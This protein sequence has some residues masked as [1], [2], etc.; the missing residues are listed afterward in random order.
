MC[1]TFG[2]NVRH[3]FHNFVRKTATCDTERLALLGAALVLPFVIVGSLYATAVPSRVLSMLFLNSAQHQVDTALASEARDLETH[4]R[5][6]STL[7]TVRHHLAENDTEGLTWVL[8]DEL[9]RDGFDTL[10]VTNTSGTVLARGESPGKR[11]DNMLLKY[12]ETAAV[13]N[14]N[15]IRTYIATPEVAMIVGA[16]IRDDHDTIIGMLFAGYQLDAGFAT[17]LKHD[18]FREDGQVA[19]FT[20]SQGV[21]GSSL[22][23]SSLTSLL[24]QYFDIGSQITLQRDIP[25]ESEIKVGTGYYPVRSETLSAP[26]GLG[27]LI[28]AEA[29]HTA[30][31]TALAAVIALLFFAL[32]ITWALVVHQKRVSGSCMRVAASATLAVFA[33][34]DIALFGLF[35]R[36][37]VHL[38]PLP[39]PIYNSTL[40]IDPESD[41][42]SLGNEKQVSILVRT[43]GEAINAIAANLSFDPS[44]MRVEEIVTDHSICADGFFI[45]KNFDNAAGTVSVVCGIPNPGFSETKGTVA[46][47]RFSPLQP[48]QLALSFASTTR[49]LANDGLGTDVLREANPASFQVASDTSSIVF[50]NT[51]P[52][53]SRWYRGRSV[54]FD[55]IPRSGSSYLYYFGSDPSGAPHTATDADGTMTLEAP[56]D[57]TYYFRLSRLADGRTSLLSTFRVHIDSKP[58]S[59]PDVRLASDTLVAGSLLRIMFSSSDDASGLQ[60][61][62]YVRLDDGVLF[63]IKSPMQLTFTSRGEHQITVRAFD[64][65]G[66]WS[67]TTKTVTVE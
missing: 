52:N 61:N 67:D 37:A 6:A 29:N 58:P 34:A 3:A 8:A 36:S 27:M 33:I 20:R 22:E 47:I 31:A 60:D 13:L 23:D 24:N 55:W 25:L 64:K 54:T 41:A 4:V 12:P 21:T 65:A 32:L 15:V 45:E 53:S 42:L 62:Y 1:D 46:D 19:F 11:G 5:A 28:F 39:F 57:G 59:A 30:I 44:R 9:R 66:N 51:H 7:E 14:G 43:G 26:L 17:H 18:Y 38:V 50:S 35:D 40:S 49:V 16:P 63:P 48:G 10:F 56:A 2:M